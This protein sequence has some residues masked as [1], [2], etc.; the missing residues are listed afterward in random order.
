ME[1]PWVLEDYLTSGLMFGKPLRKPHFDDKMLETL[2]GIPEE[3][4]SSHMG[5][6]R[7]IPY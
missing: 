7:R 2:S 5:P 4:A 3:A 6:L 1:S